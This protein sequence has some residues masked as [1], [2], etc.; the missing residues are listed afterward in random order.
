MFR[1]R[2]MSFYR[3]I[4]IEPAFAYGQIW[5]LPN[6]LSYSTY[7]Y[8]V[9]PGQKYSVFDKKWTLLYRL[10]LKIKTYVEI[11]EYI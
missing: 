3:Y 2:R 6:A 11:V 5:R 8:S 10:P 4:W 1:S 7:Q 9:P